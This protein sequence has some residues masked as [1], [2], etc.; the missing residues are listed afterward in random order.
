ME[1]FF[2]GSFYYRRMDEPNFTVKNTKHLNYNLS[3]L[4]A[5][6]QYI[7]YVTAV[8]ENGESLP[9]ETLMAWTD[10]AFPPVVEQPIVH[11]AGIILEGSSMT[12]MCHALAAPMPTISMYVGGVL[13]DKRQTRQLISIVSN[14]TRS[15]NSVSCQAENGYGDPH[16]SSRRLLIGREFCFS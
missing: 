7:G 5:T 12:V 3:N 15:M 2:L 13:V 6:S 11:P 8:N 14:V 16:Q 9:S 10:P 1:K 4:T